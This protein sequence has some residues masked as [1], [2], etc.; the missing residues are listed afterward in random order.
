M[1]GSILNV[2]PGIFSPAAF[3]LCGLFSHPSPQIGVSKMHVVSIEYVVPGASGQD[4]GI[5]GHTVPPCTT[6][7]KT[8]TI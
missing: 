1:P 6:K 4:G 2:F 5:G 7:R 3:L 8:T